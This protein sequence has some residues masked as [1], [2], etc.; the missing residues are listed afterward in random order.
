MGQR[1]AELVGQS[2]HAIDD[3][4]SKQ[5]EAE[6]QGLRREVADGQSAVPPAGRLGLEHGA[7]LEKRGKRVCQVEQI[8]GQD[9]WFQLESGQVEHFR[10]AEDPDAQTPARPGW[11]RTISGFCRRMLS[12]SV[13]PLRKILWI[14]A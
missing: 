9:V 3:F 13:S 1:P 5:M 6:F 8:V 4:D 11:L 10:Q 14:R 12:G 7:L 2:S